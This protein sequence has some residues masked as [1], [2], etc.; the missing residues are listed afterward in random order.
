MLLLPIDFLASL[1]VLLYFSSPLQSIVSRIQGSFPQ[2]KWLF[3]P[4]YLLRFR[5]QHTELH[6]NWSK[7]SIYCR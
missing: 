6:Q 3:Q 7:A 2:E 1:P 4:E 5:T